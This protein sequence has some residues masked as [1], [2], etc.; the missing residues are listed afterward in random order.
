MK[1]DWKIL[2]LTSRKKRAHENIADNDTAILKFVEKG[3]LTFVNAAGKI[4]SL[5]SKNAS[6]LVIIVRANVQHA[7]HNLIIRG[8]IT[9]YDVESL[10]Y[11]IQCLIHSDI[12][13]VGYL[14]YP[15]ED[16]NA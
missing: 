6:E 10:L 2:N 5:R 13:F 16:L 8:G 14:F 11:D 7:M 9:T 3:M 15:M 1:S 12:V 4:L